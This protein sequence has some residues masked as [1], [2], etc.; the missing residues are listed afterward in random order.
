M[1]EKKFLIA[2]HPVQ[3]KAATSTRASALRLCVSE[4][5]QETTPACAGGVR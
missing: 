4:R 3:A 1:N 2:A 5:A